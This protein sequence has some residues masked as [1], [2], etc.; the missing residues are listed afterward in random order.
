MSYDSYCISTASAMSLCRKLPQFKSV[1]FFFVKFGSLAVVV[2]LFVAQIFIIDS[3]FGD[4][5]I[6]VVVLW[7]L[8]YYYL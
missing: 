5:V 1:L 6:V 3:S 7:V 4:V 2:M 8:H